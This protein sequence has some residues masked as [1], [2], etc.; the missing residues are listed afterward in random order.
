MSAAEVEVRKVLA[1]ELSET[2]GGKSCDLWPMV[3]RSREIL[4]R[5]GESALCEGSLG[6]L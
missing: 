5:F 4:G 3:A 1:M 2:I 6:S